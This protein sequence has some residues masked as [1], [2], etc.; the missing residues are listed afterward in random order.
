M[1][2]AS[3]RPAASP[4]LG[5][6][7]GSSGEGLSPFAVKQQVPED[8]LADREE[9]T[10]S[11]Q[12]GGLEFPLEQRWQQHKRHPLHLSHQEV[13]DVTELCLGVIEDYEE[14]KAAVASAIS[15]K[16]RL[17][18]SEAPEEGLE[19]GLGDRQHKRSAV[20][21][22]GDKNARRRTE[23]ESLFVDYAA[24]RPAYFQEL[25]VASAEAASDMRATVDSTLSEADVAIYAKR[26]VAALLLASPWPL[27]LEDVR[28]R[29][30]ATPVHARRRNLT[31]L[32]LRRLARSRFLLRESEQRSFTAL[33]LLE[34]F[35]SL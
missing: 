21:S 16:R 9:P 17:D 30:Q 18:D 2:G 12:A 25:R 3:S 14:E 7:A 33:T 35:S 6:S 34:V 31:V 15:S 22:P 28:K 11:R 23:E 13:A 1:P 20:N 5:F 10:S 19:D 24:L 32:V 8:G 27:R 26:T 29:W 4:S